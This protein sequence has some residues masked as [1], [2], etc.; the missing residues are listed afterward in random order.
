MRVAWRQTCGLFRPCWGRGAPRRNGRDWT[1]VVRRL[2]G[3]PRAGSRLC[4]LTAGP[5]LSF[6][7][8]QNVTAFSRIDLIQ[9]TDELVMMAHLLYYLL[10]LI[11]DQDY[12]G[13]I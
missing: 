1:S 10:R 13:K 11:P 7:I 12:H 4:C 9:R 2:K 3:D 6:S 5:K 8:E